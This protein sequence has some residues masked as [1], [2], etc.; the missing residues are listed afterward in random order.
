MEIGTNNIDDEM[1]VWMSDCPTVS[2]TRI[3][4]KLVR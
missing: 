2:T 3:I 1:I 4:I